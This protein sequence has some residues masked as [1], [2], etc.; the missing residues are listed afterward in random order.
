MRWNGL[1]M[2]DAVSL[3]RCRLDESGCLFL[4]RA[5]TNAPVFV[6]LPPRVVALLSSL[7]SENPNYF[8]WS[9]RGD[10]PRA[11]KAYQR[12]SLS[13]KPHLLEHCGEAWI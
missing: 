12:T 8:F 7:P 11:I 1:A 2:M 9:G 13:R 3:E 4:G 6:P 10:A 5:K